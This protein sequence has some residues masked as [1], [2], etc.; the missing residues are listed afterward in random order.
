[1]LEAVWELIGKQGSVVPAGVGEGEGN[2]WGCEAANVSRLGL[3]RTLGACP[4]VWVLSEGSEEPLMNFREENDEVGVWGE[5]KS[6]SKGVLHL[7]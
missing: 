1:M 7:L 4:G 6:G 3:S 2:E 5:W